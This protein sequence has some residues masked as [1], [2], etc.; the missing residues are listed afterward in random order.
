[1]LALGGISAG[2]FC[3][4]AVLAGEGED[5]FGMDDDGVTSSVL[6]GDL[7]LGMAFMCVGGCGY[8]RERSP[9]LVALPVA[10]FVFGFFAAFVSGAR[11]AWL[12]MPLLVLLMFWYFARERGVRERMLMLGGILLFAL[13]VYLVPQSGVAERVASLFEDL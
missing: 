7:S 6:F 10:G 13:A 12:A 8:F 9:W 5:L 2:M 3:L 11:G 1:G 4:S